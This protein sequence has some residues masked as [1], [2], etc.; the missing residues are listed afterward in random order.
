MTD[1]E[2]V[3]TNEVLAPSLSIREKLLARDDI[4]E[5]L[6]RSKTKNLSDVPDPSRRRF[7]STARNVAL[8][9]GAGL[10]TGTLLKNI[11]LKDQPRQVQ[12]FSP[13]AP[14]K[15]INFFQEILKPFIEGVKQ[16]R[17]ERAR[18]DPEYDHR[19]D[20][21]LNENRVN[22]L[23]F[24]YWEEHG[25]T[26]EDYA[27]S[28]TILS[29]NCETDEVVAIH[30]SRDIRVPELERFF[31]NDP[32]NTQRVRFLFKKGGFLKMQTIAESM[33]GLAIDYQ[34]VLKDTLIRDAIDKFADG[35]LLIDV[36]KDHHTQPFRFDRRLY[37]PGGAF[38][39]R[40]KQWMNTHELM[41]YILAEDLEPRGKEDERSFRKNDVFDAL[42]QKIKDKSPGNTFDLFL[43]VIQ[44]RWVN[45]LQY[46]FQPN[47]ISSAVDIAN[48]LLRTSR[49]LFMKDER[50]EYSLPRM[51]KHQQIIFHDP[52][53]GDG[54]VSRVYNI[55]S[56]NPERKDHPSVVRE[57]QA[58]RLPDWMLIPDGGDPYAKDLVTG[59]WQSTRKL[60]KE[61]L[62]S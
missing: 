30:F 6:G 29:Y 40:G 43:F 60:V 9:A 19:V 1:T 23:L 59:Y 17:A 41:R 44:Q 13:A 4:D 37:D 5:I 8:T 15:P 2:P 18:N 7:L 48:R 16:K 10:A 50:F 31:P 55:D 51:Q 57:V 42:V 21:E 56:N 34:L 39:R 24:G 49:N 11:L 54:G 35:S 12:E 62:S 3:S 45:N 32:I 26:Y 52:Y 27:G 38:I 28:P 53:F 14:E 58:G 25:N 46:D 20:R 61:R 36:A 47:L 22:L 33:S